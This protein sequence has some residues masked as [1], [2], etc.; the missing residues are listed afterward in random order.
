MLI[1]EPDQRL[2][3]G[4]LALHWYTDAIPMAS[5]N[6]KD[7]L[8]KEVNLGPQELISKP[9]P[10]SAGHP[11]DKN[12]S[13]ATLPG[14][15][16]IMRQLKKKGRG[17]ADAATTI[18]ANEAASGIA[19]DDKTNGDLKITHTQSSSLGAGEVETLNELRSD[20]GLLEND[21]GL[22]ENDDEPQPAGERNGIYNRD[23]TNPTDVGRTVGIRG[24]GHYKTYKYM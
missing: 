7:A 3:A 22:L 20:D 8:G 15:T 4:H 11:K 10:D 18:T 9:T 6:N 21:D 16:M 24:S 19:N 13:G 5:A 2:R 17:N 12:S 14:W 1:Y 23:G